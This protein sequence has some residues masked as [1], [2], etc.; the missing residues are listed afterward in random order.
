MDFYHVLVVLKRLAF[1]F[2]SG[3]MCITLFSSPARVEPTNPNHNT[4]NY[5]MPDYGETLIA[6]HRVG[7][8]NAPENTLR[9][10]KTC[11]ESDTRIDTLEM[12]LQLTSD[13]RLVLFHDLFLDEKSDSV[14]VFGQKNVPIFAKTYDELHQLNMGEFYSHDGEKPFAGLRGDDIPDDL[15]IVAVEDVFD[16]VE[17]N[18]PGKFSYVVEIKYPHPWM[19]KMID[20]LY[21]ILSDRNLCDRVIIGSFWNDASHYIDNH[22]KGKLM[23]SANP[24][25]IINF[26]GSFTRNEKLRREDIYF[27]SLEMPYYWDDGRLLLGNLG[28]TEFIDYAHKY[29]ISVQYWTVD[30]EQD[31]RDLYIGG[32]D[33]LMTDHPERAERVIN[34]MRAERGEIQ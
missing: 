4:G 16:Y 1:F 25:E 13:G 27:M 23:R 6:A 20:S 28:K 21:K 34:E 33:M 24:A 2:I 30:K 8:G 5:F 9:A 14:E 17:T 3:I 19:P 18:A 7:K 32:A 29:G 10:I 31:I 11:L 12:D 15:R 22:Y 26:Y